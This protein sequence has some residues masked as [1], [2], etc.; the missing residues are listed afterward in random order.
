MNFWH[1]LSLLIFLAPCA[2]KSQAQEQELLLKSGLIKVSDE[3]QT[4]Y[5]SDELVNGKYYR[6]I[7]FDSTP[8]SDQKAHYAANGIELLQY[9]P[10]HAYFAAV[11]EQADWNALPASANVLYV[12]GRYKM[13]PNVMANNIPHWSLFG[14]DQVELSVTFYTNLNQEQVFQK[15]L[16]DGFGPLEYMGQT[17]IHVRFPIH[18]ISELYE[19]PYVSFAEEM[20]S[21]EVPENEPGRLLHR[22]N[23]LWST[24]PNG[25]Q[26][27]GDGVVVMMQDDGLIGPHIDYTGRV[28]ESGCNNCSS[29]VNND[30]GDHVAGTI[31]G[32]GNLDPYTRGMA[33]GAD[34]LVYG[35][36]NNNYDA[37][38][39]LYANDDLVITSKSYGNNCNS[40]YTGLTSE[41][42]QQI[43]QM[44][45][46]TH[47]FSAGNSGTD[48]CGYGAGAGWGN[49]TGGHKSGKNVIAVGNLLSTDF[50]ASS[51]SRGPAT[52]GRIKPDIC[53][54][55]TSVSSTLPN[56][57]YASFTGTSMACP[58]VAGTIAQ[59]YDAFRDI[60]GDNPSSA[61]IKG[62]VLNTAEDLGN[63]GPDFIYGWGRINARRAYQVFNDQTFFVDTI[64]QGATNVHTITVPPGV[65]ELRIM[66]YWADYEGAQNA[67]P[68]LV[69]DIDMFVT[70]PSAGVSL[71]WILDPSPS[72]SALNTPAIPGADHLNNMEQVVIENPASGSYN[73][74]LDGFNIPQGPQG[75]VVVYSFVRDELVI[76][77]PNG[78]EGIEP[79]QV[80]RIYWD[81][82]EG[83]TPFTLEYSLDDGGSWNNIGTAIADQRQVSW[84]P[85][86]TT[87]G[88]AKIRISRGAQSDES[89]E[90]FSIL[91]A[92]NNLAFNWI[93]DDSLEL[94]WDGEPGANAYEVSMLGAKYMDSIETTSDTSVVLYLPSTLDTWF[95]VT[96]LGPDG[97]RSERAIAIHKV[98][99][100]LNCFWGQPTA[101][102]TIDCE[103]PG[104]GYC[105][106]FTSTSTN[107]DNSS[108][109]T[110][111]FPGGTPAVSTDQF[112]QVC[113]STPGQYD[114][115]LVVT[116]LGGTDSLFTA[117]AVNIIPTGSLPYFEG[118][119]TYS[120]LT[121]IDEWTV[122][123][124]GNSQGFLISSNALSGSKS[125]G[126]LNFLQNGSFTD[127]LISGPIDLSSLTPA[128]Q[129]TLSFRYSYRKKAANDFERLQLSVKDDCLGSWAVRKT[130]AGIL[131]G[132]IVEPLMWNPSSPSDW[133]TVHVTNITSQYFYPDF[134]FKFTFESGGGNNIY[135]DDIN[136]YQGE[137]SDEIVLVGLDELSI[138]SFKVFPNPTS[139]DVNIAFETNA[140]QKTT[141]ILRDITGKLVQSR[142][143]MAGQG[144]NL[145]SLDV[146]NVQS[147]VY[148]VSIVIG[149]SERTE[150][151]IIE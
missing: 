133:V 33:H 100:E 130:L 106:N 96:S 62:T 29:N 26:Y 58:G 35:A 1:L 125:A 114:V 46:L 4:A 120:T 103:N 94:F 151:I 23:S 112:P 121:N 119:E 21:P 93:C 95:S 42:D 2:L 31:M 115:S 80:D 40:G 70:D 43:R 134:R 137:P 15:L 89:D 59:L 24:A 104:T 52:D 149:N 72:A 78:G 48:D 39:N 56:N 91:G 83:T 57:T 3:H 127:E 45:N 8:T 109:Y 7:S 67:A 145:A 122:D 84:S 126:L 99:G 108:Q 87:S 88:L 60:Y 79:S 113:Y 61:L 85:P 11:S 131:L 75:Y 124:P 74:Q 81:A 142:E 116:N 64:A 30:H 148:L 129:M 47:V 69:N 22:S 86:T 27:R 73:I 98:P 77:Y 111:Y 101:S 54:V 136:I 36:G 76:T 10:K 92:P 146:S 37:V 17:R 65:S 105:V 16:E 63:E 147:G 18:H 28:D 20:P 118:F 44:P 117:N 97:A 139:D 49:I 53:A 135:I 51:S 82:S 50:I 12:E 66:T 90:V 19:M 143:I 144:K 150:R 14:D 68:A 128:D 141:I 25:L 140:S 38:P 55:G 138:G 123:S 110:W 5:T 41:L 13:S 6:I 132:D 102:F 71:P 34:L 107:A 32:A 9:L